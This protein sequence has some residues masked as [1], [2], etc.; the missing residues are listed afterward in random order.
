MRSEGLN[1]KGHRL[2]GGA[3]RTILLDDYAKQAPADGQI[4]VWSE[5]RHLWVPRALANADLAAVSIDALSDVVVTTPVVRD[6]LVWSGSAWINGTVV[7]QAF[8]PTV[9]FGATGA[10]LANVDC[11]YT[12]IGYWTRA[13]YRFRINSAPAAGTMFLSFP[14]PPRD[15][16][17]GF[18]ANNNIRIGDAGVLDV[19]GPFASYGFARWNDTTTWRV[20]DT[21]GANFWTNTFPYTLVGGG[22]GVGDEFY[23]SIQFEAA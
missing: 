16:A 20:T 14:I 18:S 8:T 7:W 23:A 3:T 4:A 1:P 11:R 10:T 21:A 13:E 6:L 12:R 15:A 2:D 5:T 22:A 19:S 9:L 17:A